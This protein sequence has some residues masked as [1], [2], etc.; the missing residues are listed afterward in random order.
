MAYGL[1]ATLT[2]SSKFIDYMSNYV[3]NLE[4]ALEDAR[5][6]VEI[7][8]N[9]YYESDDYYYGA[10]DTAKQFLSVALDIMDKSEKGIPYVWDSS[11]LQT[12]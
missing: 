1:R 6:N 10:I 2:R 8:E 5:N 12:Q 9:E 3:V 4:Q 11:N 7:P